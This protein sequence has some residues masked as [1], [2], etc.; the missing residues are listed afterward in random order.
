MASGIGGTLRFVGLVTGITGLGAVLSSETK[1]RFVHS[2]PAL[3]LPHAFGEAPHQIV[4]RI[5]AGDIPGVVAQTPEPLRA[6]VAELSR[7]S[8]GAGFALVLLVAG[9]VAAL[10]GGLTFA[11]VSPAETAPLRLRAAPETVAPE[12]P[13]RTPWAVVFHLMM[14][15]YLKNRYPKK[16]LQ[17]RQFFRGDRENPACRDHKPHTVQL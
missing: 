17:L 11:F 8:F 14:T 2:A 16:P 15:A 6:A 9:A 4:S 10:T 3:P 12:L 1:R 5:V 7:A 13:T